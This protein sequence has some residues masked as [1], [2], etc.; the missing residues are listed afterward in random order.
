[1]AKK[2]TFIRTSITDA[3]RNTIEEDYPHIIR[4]CFAA[5]TAD[6]RTRLDA[7]LADPKKERVVFEFGDETVTIRRE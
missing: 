7:F 6:V 4:D 5:C 1:M 3:S 2:Y